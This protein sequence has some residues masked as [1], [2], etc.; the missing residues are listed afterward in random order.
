MH[1]LR[2]EIVQC[3]FLSWIGRSRPERLFFR[4]Q[5]DA[6]RTSLQIRDRSGKPVTNEGEKS[7]VGAG[8]IDIDRFD[9]ARAGG[10]G[11]K[12][13]HRQAG[14]KIAFNP[15]S[16]LQIFLRRQM[17]GNATT[18]AEEQWSMENDSENG[19]DSQHDR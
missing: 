10:N 1:S 6:G 11:V 15:E 5:N 9:V 14:E 16:Q 8:K 18:D 7:V 13:S 17:H 2:K 19:D 3:D 12:I 4:I